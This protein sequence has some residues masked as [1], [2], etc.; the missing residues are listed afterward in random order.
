MVALEGIAYLYNGTISREILLVILHRRNNPPIGFPL[1]NFRVQRDHP[2]TM[3]SLILDEPKELPY[4]LQ[5]LVVGSYLCKLTPSNLTMPS[6]SP[7]TSHGNKDSCPRTTQARVCPT[8][9][10]TLDI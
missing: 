3:C 8:A 4:R 6:P 1:C 7:T 5:T 10:T 2:P 9:T